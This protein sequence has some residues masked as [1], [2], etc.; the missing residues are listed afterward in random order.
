MSTLDLDFIDR[1]W[2]SGIVLTVSGSGGGRQT[3][4]TETRR[5]GFEFKKFP[6]KTR[7]RIQHF[8]SFPPRRGDE[9]DGQTT[10]VLFHRIRRTDNLLNSLTNRLPVFDH[11][12]NVLPL[13]RLLEIIIT[14]QSK[15]LA[16]VIAGSTKFLVVSGDH[17]HG[18]RRRGSNSTV[19]VSKRS[20]S[21]ARSLCLL[22][23]SISIYEW[24]ND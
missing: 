1:S 10:S 12:R 5:R 2:I 8:K 13:T 19:V 6:A 21:I 24:T 16:H 14:A 7:V 23:H 11:V 9:S 4:E 17:D 20:M 18:G 22:Y 15:R 3:R